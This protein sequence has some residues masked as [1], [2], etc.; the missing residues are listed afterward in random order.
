MAHSVMMS[1]TPKMLRS[2]ELKAVEHQPSTFYTVGANLQKLQSVP[3]Q[4]H[5]ALLLP[6]IRSFRKHQKPAWYIQSQLPY[7]TPQSLPPMQKTGSP[8]SLHTVLFLLLAFNFHI[9]KNCRKKSKTNIRA[10]KEHQ[11]GVPCL[12]EE[13]RLTVVSHAWSRILLK[14]R[15]NNLYPFHWPGVSGMAAVTDRES[16]TP[17]CILKSFY[18]QE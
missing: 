5:K 1:A 12:V 8:E 3:P 10:P 11:L 14:Q 16:G 9:R 2:T 6:V 17:D 15:Q 4:E 7:T 18:I 13:Q